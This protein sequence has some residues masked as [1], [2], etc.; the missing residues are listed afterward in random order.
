MRYGSLRNYKADIVKLTY[1]IVRVYRVSRRMRCSKYVISVDAIVSLI[2]PS[3]NPAMIIDSDS[4]RLKAFLR[5]GS[6]FASGRRRG[7]Y[8]RGSQESHKASCPRASA[9][10]SEY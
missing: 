7:V 10:Q 1:D 2:S 6:D 9:N 5:H 4:E 3:A 8:G